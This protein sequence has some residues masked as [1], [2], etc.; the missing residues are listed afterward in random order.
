MPSP[1]FFMEPLCV[2]YVGGCSNSF[3]GDVIHSL[4]FEAVFFFSQKKIARS[5]LVALSIKFVIFI[6]Q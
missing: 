3:L 4:P 6:L 5:N 1:G 2:A